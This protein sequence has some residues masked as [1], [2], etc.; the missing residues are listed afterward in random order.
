MVVAELTAAG[1]AGALRQPRRRPARRGI[2]LRPAA[3]GRSRSKHPWS[4]EP[5]SPTLGVADGAVATSTTLRRRW[6]VDGARA[7]TSSTRGPASRRRRDLV[8]VT[9]V[10]GEAWSAEVLAKAALLRGSE[11]RSDLLDGRRRGARGRRRRSRAHHDR[12]RAVHRRATPRQPSDRVRRMTRRVQ[13]GRIMTQQRKQAAA[14]RPPSAPVRSL[15]TGISAIGLTACMAVRLA[16]EQ[17]VDRGEDRAPRWRRPAASTSSTSSGSTTTT[18]ARRT[19]A[20]APPTIVDARRPARSTR[21][22][23][24]RK[25]RAARRAAPP[26][27]R[28]AS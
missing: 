13:G 5:L 15:V 8:A 25:R 9:V 22:P 21:R 1:A 12:P 26:R 18:R 11:R 7:T 23:P 2:G 20:A 4:D 16:H 10:A 14:S 27:R 3:T 17:H 28:T 6:T 19:Q 24:R